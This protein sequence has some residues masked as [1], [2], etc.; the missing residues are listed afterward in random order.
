MAGGHRRRP[1]GAQAVE[2]CD[3]QDTDCNGVVDDTGDGNC[4]P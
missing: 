2:A 1:S 3:G 4:S